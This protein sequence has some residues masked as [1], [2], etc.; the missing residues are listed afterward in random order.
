[1]T[2]QEARRTKHA[3]VVR[4]QSCQLLR[5]HVSCSKLCSSQSAALASL[6]FLRTACSSTSCLILWR[7]SSLTSPYAFQCANTCS[8]QRTYRQVSRRVGMRTAV[9]IWVNTG[10]HSPETAKR[11]SGTRD[12]AP[13]R[14]YRPNLGPYQALDA[15]STL[16]Q[17]EGPPPCQP[18]T[19]VEP[20]WM[21]LLLR[22]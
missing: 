16:M 5:R 1:M 14:Q 3:V 19:G 18:S 13:P 8:R 6:T 15:C 17:W 9:M 12:F 11:V 7:S 20:S 2:R 4:M 22:A 21:S 10:R